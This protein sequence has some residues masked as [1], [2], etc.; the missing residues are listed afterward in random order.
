[1]CH[2]GGAV[3]LFSRQNDPHDASGDPAGPPPCRACGAPMDATQDWCLSC[4]TAAP[5]RLGGRP[6]FRAASSVAALTLVLV[7][8]A[9]AASYAALS[10]DAGSDAGQAAPAN[11]APVPGAVAQ[12]PDGAVPAPAPVTPPTPT[13]PSAS[14]PAPL[15]TAPKPTTPT[16]APA[17]PTPTL[18]KPP[19]TK[20]PS[21]S[22]KS[23]P[24]T[25]KPPALKAVSFPKSAMAE[26]DPSK[27]IVIS[28]D[29]TD[30]HDGKRSTAWSV[31]AK[32]DGNA[33]QVGL[34]VKLGDPK[35]VKRLELRTT[36]PGGRAEIYAAVGSALPPDILDTR[37][38]HV[39]SRSKLGNSTAAGNKSSDDL[40]KIRFRRGGGRYRY[41]V[42]W[43]TNP[44]P[45]GGPTVKI[46]ELRLLG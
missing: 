1:M 9:G 46:T 23:T 25:D 27:R 31:T 32:N 17:K 18:T 35:S 42:V 43:L 37:W 11:V 19:A 39:G 33:M 7:T 10:S 44:P 3:H 20:T 2:S 38:E 41:V 12:V 34:L 14:T 24:T 16:P 4:G 5:G 28:G 8:G 22:T 15:P 45:Q 30:A 13:P 6:G 29:P 40:E 21:T 36:T 26:Y